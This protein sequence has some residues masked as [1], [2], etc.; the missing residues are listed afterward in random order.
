[1]NSPIVYEKKMPYVPM[2]L[3]DWTEQQEKRDKAEKEF[4]EGFNKFV[5]DWIGSN[6][7]NSMEKLFKPAQ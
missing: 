6:I 2:G 7:N 3:G 4:D 1:M 5:A